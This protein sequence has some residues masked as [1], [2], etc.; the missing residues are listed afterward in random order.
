MFWCLNSTD[1]SDRPGA[2]GPAPCGGR[3][4]CTARRGAR[5][6]ACRSS[7]RRSGRPPARS[8]P[9]AAGFSSSAASSPLRTTVKPSFRRTKFAW[10]G[11]SPPLN[12]SGCRMRP[13]RVAA[14]QAD[15]RLGR[16]SLALVDEFV[17]GRR[18]EG[19]VDPGVQV[20]QRPEDVFLRQTCGDRLRHGAILLR[21]NPP[22]KPRIG[23]SSV[24]AAIQAKMPAHRDAR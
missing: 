20:G 13:E 1:P 22:D 14:G 9:C 5:L 16:V 19:V 17:A 21:S 6:R 24:A 4:C 15:D 8:S 7:R 10:P 12:S 3:P 18:A 11:A 2:A 23:S